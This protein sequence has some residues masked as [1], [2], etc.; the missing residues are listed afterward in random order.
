MPNLILWSSLLFNSIQKWASGGG[1]GGA[2][3]LIVYFIVWWRGWTMP[4]IWYALIFFVFFIV[5]SSFIVW[6]DE[7]LAHLKTKADLSAA[8]DQK[9]VK[10]HGELLHAIM[11]LA[12]NKK[13][14]WAILTISI[15]NSGA[16]SVVRGYKAKVSFNGK[17]FDDLHP[18]IF[19]KG[20]RIRDEKG[21]E[22]EMLYPQQMI[23]EKTSVPVVRGDTKTGTLIFLIKDASDF[24]SVS[25]EW[26]INFV[27][28]TG[29]NEFEIHTQKAE[30]TI[31]NPTNLPHYPGDGSVESVPR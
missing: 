14:V 19:P 10:F 29:K 15:W 12:D 3:L 21:V 11:S 31:I 25:P 17:V 4:K 9:V 6:R 18:Q 8:L 13:D 26:T 7:H 30:K 28:Y 16:D 2:V 24:V 22:L 23:T 27:D 1:L 5:G 20:F